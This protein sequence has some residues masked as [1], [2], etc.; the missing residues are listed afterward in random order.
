MNDEAQ[1]FLDF[2]IETLG[3]DV[4]QKLTQ[5][6]ERR[7]DKI[8]ESIKRDPLAPSTIAERVLEWYLENYS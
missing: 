6:A 5:E 2:V 3:E 8:V 1:W 4:N 7:M